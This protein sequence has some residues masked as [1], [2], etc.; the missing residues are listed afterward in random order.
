MKDKHISLEN[1]FDDGIVQY[2]RP[3]APSPQCVEYRLTV[4]PTWVSI[5]VIG[6]SWNE[7]RCWKVL[8]PN[9]KTVEEATAILCDL[10]NLPRKNR[11]EMLIK[12]S[13]NF[14]WSSHRTT[15]ESEGARS[16]SHFESQRPGIFYTVKCN[17]NFVVSETTVAYAA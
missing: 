8:H 2:W 3:I 14:E 4:E 12:E 5:D 10:L 16:F 13:T 1:Y 7:R 6:W 15:P 17:A 9:I 11:R